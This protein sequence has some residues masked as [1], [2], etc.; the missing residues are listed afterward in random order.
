MA[1]LLVLR[2]VHVMGG[3]FWVG[4]MMWMAF[5]LMPT[6]AAAGPA[7][8]P[9]IAGLQQ[10]KLFVWLPVVAIATMLAGIRLM[11]IQSAN[12]SAIYFST[13]MGRTYLAAGSMAILAFAIGLT[14]NRPAMNRI[15]AITA[16]MPSA[17]ESSRA[18]MQAE[19]ATL[20]KRSGVMTKVVT[21]LLIGAA[22]GMSVARYA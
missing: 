15:P 2:V 13:P 12:F 21:W 16:A 14:V 17:D 9:V 20:R 7:A 18:Q 3:I 6:M 22:V 8:G 4:G 10:R 1:E 11:M 19:M 5:F